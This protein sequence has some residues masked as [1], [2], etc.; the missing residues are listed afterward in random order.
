MGRAE[1]QSTGGGWYQTRMGGH[2]GLG[3]EEAERR[4]VCLGASSDGK[5]QKIEGAYSTFPGGLQDVQSLPGSEQGGDE[6]GGPRKAEV[7]SHPLG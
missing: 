2:L 6:L 5:Q 4:H 7:C 3:D 1:S